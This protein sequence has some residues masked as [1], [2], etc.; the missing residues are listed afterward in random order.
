MRSKTPAAWFERFGLNKTIIHTLWPM[1]DLIYLYC[2]NMMWLFASISSAI[3]LWFIWR[4]NIAFHWQRRIKCDNT[5]SLSKIR[6]PMM[7]IFLGWLSLAVLRWGWSS[8]NRLAP[9]LIC[10]EYSVRALITNNT[11]AVR[12][13]DDGMEPTTRASLCQETFWKLAQGMD[14][15]MDGPGA[16]R[17]I[18]LKFCDFN[19]EYTLVH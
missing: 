15:W 13:R 2:S 14:R 11:R 19:Q 6:M 9:D 7:R 17:V 4:K 5:G 18:I 8:R 16:A 1:P 3:D 10:K 12:E